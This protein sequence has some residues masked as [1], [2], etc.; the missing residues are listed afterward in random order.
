MFQHGELIKLKINKYED[1]D[2]LLH[3]KINSTS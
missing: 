2:K 3:A 1:N